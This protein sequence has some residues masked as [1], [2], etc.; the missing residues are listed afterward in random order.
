MFPK[1]LHRDMLRRVHYAH[2]GVVSTLSLARESIVK[3]VNLRAFDRKQPT[4][5]LVPHQK[6][7]TG[8]GRKSEMTYFLTGVGTISFAI[9]AIEA[10]WPETKG[11]LSHLVLP[12]FD[13][14]YELSVYDGVVQEKE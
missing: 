12:Y 4:E 13:I 3:G 2:S 7:P 6:C 10:G 11:D 14:R 8:H 9:R 1:S 5:A